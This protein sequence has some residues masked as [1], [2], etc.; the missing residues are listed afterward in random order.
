V[1][2]EGK[3]R[4]QARVFI[5]QGQRPGRV[6]LTVPPWPTCRRARGLGRAEMLRRRRLAVVYWSGS[7]DV[8]LFKLKPLPRGETEAS[9]LGVSQFSCID[10][11]AKICSSRCQASLLSLRLWVLPE[12]F[13]C[14]LPSRDV[15][16]SM[17]QLEFLAFKTIHIGHFIMDSFS[18]E[19]YFEVKEI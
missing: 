9:E 7:V 14:R 10:V 16:R 4:E 8:K 18:R 17:E 3:R 12:C 1:T 11:C 6:G 19:I 2:C 13:V 15:W 5:G